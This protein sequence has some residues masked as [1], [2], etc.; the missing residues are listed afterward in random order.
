[1]TH[2][3][4]CTTRPYSQLSFADACRHISAAGYSDVAVF[5]HEVTSS[6][7][8]EQVAEVR[9]AAADTGLNPSM[10]LGGSDLSGSLENSVADLKRLIDNTAGLGAKWLL[11][12]GIS[13]EEHYGKFFELMRQ[14][15]PHAE[16][17]GVCIT[18]KPHGGI[19]LTVDDLIEAHHEVNH[20]AFGI[21][22]DP[23]NIIYYTKGELRPEPF[24]EELASII[25][26]F[27]IKDCVVEDG[28]PD[29]MVTP[30]EGL[31]DFDTV[32]G[33]LVANGFKGPLY[34]ECVGG[35]TLDEIDRNVGASLKF[36]QGILGTAAG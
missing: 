24:V 36:V 12:C 7:S 21:C 15:S 2:T 27:I 3:I 13:N 11:D 16:A 25:S 34:L 4:G 5:G 32:I 29:V 35:K 17:C 10:L 18:L 30:G 20:P 33:G 1:M 8:N 28:T 26:T 19:T 9:K 6:S 23:G 22:Y 14:A 31:V